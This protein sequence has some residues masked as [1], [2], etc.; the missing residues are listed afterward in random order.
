EYFFGVL[1][2]TCSA[3]KLQFSLANLMK[4]LEK[5]HG[6]K[7]ILLLDEYDAPILSAWENGY[8]KEGID[9]MRGFLGSAL[10]TNPFL[11][12]AVLTGVTRVSKESIFSGL[13][14]LDVCGVLSDTYA[15]AF[16]FTQ[17][18]AARLMEE[19][20]VGDKMPEL[21]KWYDGYRFGQV[22]IYNPWSV[23]NFIKNGCRFRPYWLNTS[24]NSI[25][26]DLLKRVNTRRHK[27]LQGLVQGE[28]VESPVLENIVYADI[29]TN[30]DALFMM[31]MTTGYLKP[32][33][34]WQDGDCA[35]WVRLKIPNLEVRMAYRKEIL[36][37][38]VPSQGETLLRD[39]LR[40]MTD[41]DAEGF[42]E[43]LSDILR[44]FVSYH[45]TAQ[46]ESFYHGL[47][48]GLSVML[49]GEYRV[50]SNRESGYGRFD[51]AFFPLRDGAPGVILE[52]KSAKSEEAM[53]EKAK[54]ALHQIE[55]KVYI[56]ELAQQG[57][58]EVWKYG[59]AFCGKKVW[60]EQG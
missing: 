9:F 57:V 25:L 22:E 32:V 56:T 1:R 53:E 52:L 29:H 19:C 10:K 12:I 3:E 36:G 21:K 27:E 30:R 24:G 44:D 15:D 50:A 51:I 4:M 35:D 7:P 13:N 38:I 42:R 6:K 40:S 55:E 49:E 28:A 59:I 8:Y 34:T 33:E 43:N 17:E 14:N 23:I 18:E 45:D 2:E 16:G 48:L 58:K 47:I 37:H 60:L 20:G 46:P 39:M 11:G 31:L 5:H 41:G 54:E 26:K